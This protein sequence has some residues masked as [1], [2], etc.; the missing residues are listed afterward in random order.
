MQE[1][2]LSQQLV[3]AVVIFFLTLTLNVY[4]ITGCKKENGLS[5][6]RWE[7]TVCDS[8]E[9]NTSERDQTDSSSVQGAWTSS[10]ILSDSVSSAPS[11][12]FLPHL[13]FPPSWLQIYSSSWLW[14]AC[15]PTNLYPAFLSS[16]GQEC[17]NM[18]EA[19]DHH[20]GKCQVHKINANFMALLSHSAKFYETEKTWKLMLRGHLVGRKESRLFP[21]PSV[22]SSSVRFTARGW[23][24]PWL[25]RL[26]LGQLGASQVRE[27]WWRRSWERVFHLS[28]PNDSF[29]V[30][31]WAG[32]FG[33]RA[34]GLVHK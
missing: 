16:L 5:S 31:P 3:G 10:F 22:G 19:L 7:D 32:E 6:S 13:V 4:T 11:L 20:D 24:L 15:P 14:L 21:T 2:F 34:I 17:Y 12:L 9:V 8:L 29:L 25:L 33:P 30:L 27:E 28:P 26:Q 18:R 1:F 23:R